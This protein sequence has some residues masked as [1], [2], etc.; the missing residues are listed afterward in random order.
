MIEFSGDAMSKYRREFRGFLDA[1]RDLEA[2]FSIAIANVF[3]T[4]ALHWANQEPARSDNDLRAAFDLSP[5]RSFESRVL[6]F[7]PTPVKRVISAVI[8]AAGAIPE[9]D[10]FSSRESLIA[11][12]QASSAKC[13]SAAR[14]AAFADRVLSDPLALSSGGLSDSER[15]LIKD[16]APDR[17]SPQVLDEVKRVN[18]RSSGIMSEYAANRMVEEKG[19][20]DSAIPRYISREHDFVRFQE[21]VY[22]EADRTHVVHSDIFPASLDSFV[23]KIGRRATVRGDIPDIFTHRELRGEKY[24]VVCP[25]GSVATL[26]VPLEGIEFLENMDVLDFDLRFTP[27]G[28]SYYVSSPEEHL[29]FDDELEPGV[30][31]ELLNRLETRVPDIGV[32]R[33][34]RDFVR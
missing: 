23:G 8:E 19:V 5:R 29:A 32:Q 13:G 12:L 10:V 2:S 4:N 7:L 9:R 1:R 27:V 30:S 21:T 22:S 31:R 24:V 26:C 11:C 3:S 17:H 25:L 15:Q 16:F 14:V 18:S 28:T 20:A 33:A 34:E 6:G